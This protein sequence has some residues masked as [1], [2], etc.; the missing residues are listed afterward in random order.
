[1]VQRATIYKNNCTY[2]FSSISA[3]WHWQTLQHLL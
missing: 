1:M 3:S 2:L